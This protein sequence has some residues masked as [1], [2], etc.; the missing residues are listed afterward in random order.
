MSMAPRCRA[1]LVSGVLLMASLRCEGGAVSAHGDP[2]EVTGG[3]RIE[4]TLRWW[5]GDGRRLPVPVGSRTEEAGGFSPP[6]SPGIEDLFQWWFGDGSR[7]PHPV[8]SGT[9]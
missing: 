8:K 3:G 4:E 5:L 7:P 6:V 2:P 1:L 9:A